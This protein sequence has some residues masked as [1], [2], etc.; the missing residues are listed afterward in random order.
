MGHHQPPQ[1]A[2]SEQG[3]CLWEKIW[4]LEPSRLGEQTLK[5][6]EW[7]FGF[8]SAKMGVTLFWLPGFY[9]RKKH[10]SSRCGSAG[11]RTRLVSMRMWVRS[12]ASLMG[13]GS[14]IATSC[15][16]GHR[17]VSDLAWLWLWRRLVA[18]ALIQPLDW[19]LP[20]ASGV[21]GKRQTEEEADRYGTA[22]KDLDYCCCNNSGQYKSVIGPTIPSRDSC[23]YHSG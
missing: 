10:E 14:G 20:C 21:A 8:P 16:V 3:W 2:G 17:C 22:E 5:D 7:D 15:S 18:A 9:I 23:C 4:N 19:E 1:S 11:L 6:G 12:L 13:S